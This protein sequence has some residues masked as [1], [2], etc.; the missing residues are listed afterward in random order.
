MIGTTTDL[1][2]RRNIVES[3]LSQA[4]K[5][6]AKQPSRMPA[7]IPMKI[8]QVSESCVRRRSISGRP[9]RPALAS[10]PASSEAYEAAN[11]ATP[12]ASSSRVTP[13][14]SMPS[15]ASARS[16]PGA[17]AMPSWIRTAGRP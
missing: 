17:A 8:H 10:I 14:R 6:G 1:I 16:C 4:A 3:G 2:I 9:A 5:S 12:S 13:A 15:P 7:P 11:F